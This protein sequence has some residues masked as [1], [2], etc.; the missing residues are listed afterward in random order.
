MSILSKLKNIL[1]KCSY[2]LKT[3]FQFACKDLKKRYAGSIGGILWAYIQ[4]LISILVF[5]FVFQVGFKNSPV[6]NVPF[7]LWLV[8][9]YVAWTY[10]NDA[11]M[12]SSN[13][14]Y[15]YSYLVKKVKFK[16]QLLPVIKVA[17]ALIIHAFFIVFIFGIYMGYKMPFYGTWFQ[18]FYYTFALSCLL[19]GISWLVSSLSVF[20]K[21]ISQIVNVL[22]Q[23]GFWMAPVFWNPDTM[24]STVVNVLKLNPFYYIV[25]GYREVFMYGKGFYEHQFL[26]IYFWIATIIIFLLGYFV[27]KRLSKHFPDL[28]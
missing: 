20:W 25:Q 4:P 22:L 27:F 9:S 15:E 1:N 19:V 21:D 17:S 3:L 7:I 24:N 5:W 26:S 12:Q 13:S 18:V 10:A 11:I 23:I 2:Y 6:D 8:P 14:L 28:L 16:I